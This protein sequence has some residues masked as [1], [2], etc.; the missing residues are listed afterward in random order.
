MKTV[1]RLEE[2]AMFGLTIYLFSLLS[3]SWWWYPVL[4]LTPDIGMLG[5]VINTKAGAMLYNLFH[6]KAI[7]IIIYVTGLIMHNE[8]LQLAGL[9]LFGHSS[10]DRLF[11]YGLKY[12]D[13]FKHTHLGMIGGK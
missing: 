9:I 10:M 5:Y 13:D 12:Q 2:A 8:M 4:L 1:I 3:F 11:G 7:A 6:H